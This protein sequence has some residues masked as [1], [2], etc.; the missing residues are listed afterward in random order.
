LTVKVLS[1][2]KGGDERGRGR[3]RKYSTSDS[4]WMK[5]GTIPGLKFKFWKSFKNNLRNFSNFQLFWSFQA[6]FFKKN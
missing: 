5:L 2:L 1:Q 3:K 6:W 4:D